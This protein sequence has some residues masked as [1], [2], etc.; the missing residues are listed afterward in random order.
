MKKDINK[1][2]IKKEK[3]GLEEQ[4]ED[5]IPS[6]KNDPTLISAWPGAK[7][8]LVDFINEMNPEL[9][10]DAG[11]DKNHFKGHIKNLIGFDARDIKGVDYIGNYDDMEAKGII[12]PNSVDVMICH[13]SLHTG[14][15]DEVE[16]NVKKCASWLK[17][18][19]LML[20]RA[21]CNFNW[22]QTD[23]NSYNWRIEDVQRW[24]NSFKLKVYTPVE[25][26]YAKDHN[27][28]LMSRFVWWWKKLDEDEY[29]ETRNEI[30]T[31]H[32]NWK[33]V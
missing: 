29:W 5:W 14:R 23:A 32:I 2:N 19:G 4:Y 1:F 24:S 33:I 22:S 26:C 27:G 31:K 30:K 17:P 21:K 3:D 9:V 7:K 13:G 15:R 12:K 11:C 10:V 16:Q 20:V 28:N 8:S 25:V 6:V 18:G